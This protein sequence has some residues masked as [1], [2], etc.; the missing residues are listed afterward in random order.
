MHGFQ[1]SRRVVAPSVGKSIERNLESGLFKDF[2]DSQLGSF[3]KGNRED[4]N[5]INRKQ[6]KLSNRYDQS[7]SAVF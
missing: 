6:I 3:I 1:Q 4:F 2:I 7:E 5:F